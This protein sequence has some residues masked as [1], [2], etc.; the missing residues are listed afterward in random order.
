MEENK[1]KEIVNFA[2]LMR[3]GLT[4]CSLLLQFNRPTSDQVQANN[5]TI[6][7]TH[8]I[9]DIFQPIKSNSG[10]TVPPQVIIINGAPGMGKT[11][12]SKEIAYRWAKSELLSD[13][14]LLFFVYLRDP[15][16]QKM[17]DFQSF[18][19]YF[20]NFDEAAAE[21]S[22][23]CAEALIKRSNDDVVVIL[24]GY[25]EC[26]NI[27]GDLFITQ[28]I[29][30]KVF[31]KSKLI[32]TSRPTATDALRRI[33][34]IRVEFE[35]MGFTD[36]SKKEYIEQELRNYPSKIEKLSSYLA[37]NSTINSICYIPMI[38]TILVCLF[39]ETEELPS[40]QTELYK[41]FI[42][43]AISRY[44]EKPDCPTPKI[45]YLEDLPQAY[46]HYMTE[47]SKFAFDTLKSNSIVFNEEDIQSLCPELSSANN[48]FQGLGLLKSTQYFSMKKINTCVT[49]NFLHLSIQEFLAAFY[50]NSLNPSNQFELLRD[51]L[52]G[53]KY[54]NT[55][56]MFTCLRKCAMFKINKYFVYVE[57]LHSDLKIMLDRIAGEDGPYKAFSVLVHH[58]CKSTGN[59][60]VFL[61]GDSKVMPED[62]ENSPANDDCNKMH[63]SL[64]L[65]SEPHHEL[66]EMFIIDNNAKKALYEKIALEL[67]FN[68]LLSVAIM[69]LSSITG[70]RA[71]TQQIH[72]CFQK[73]VGITDLIFKECYIDD[74][75]AQVI[76]QSIVSSKVP[77]ISFNCCTLTSTGTKLIFEA[78]IL[79][80]DHLQ[81]ISFIDMHFNEMEANFMEGIVFT[82]KKLA[83]LQL[84]NCNIATRILHL[85]KTKSN[86]TV[87]D[88]SNNMLSRVAIKDL[89]DVIL[90]NTELKMLRLASTSL[91]NNG[92]AIALALCKVTKLKILNLSDNCM[93]SNVA[94]ALS[95]AIDS[96][97]SLEFL[98]LG[99]MIYKQVELL[100]LHSL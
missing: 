78:L 46:K 30:R 99:I 27:S 85:I 44:V 79:V 12:L 49:Y 2:R 73:S 3:E 20:Y 51:T 54:T 34:D 31:P 6:T 47:L 8:C 88:L 64:H 14:K 95:H 22:K 86:L 9:S 21:F 98:A 40:D 29:K 19:H 24:D 39:K 84:N 25:D 87:L 70:Y 16:V 80:S 69:D 75:T 33:G 58:Y 63:L 11:T 94:T 62:K 93:P 91:H 74:E 18:I 48:D 17:H 45:L 92:I 50:I 77:R 41:D 72:Y 89:E 82:A 83:W 52:F 43:Y 57:I 100:L 71:S 32:V 15:K 61:F 59:F 1:E 36:D 55:W 26:L 67:Q 38:M 53:E 23:Q 90:A 7:L 76:S 4:G 60:Q 42:T 97:C 66:M 28:I 96:N 65:A 37:N 35:V 5:S 81:V 56:H 13:I 10:N 68:K